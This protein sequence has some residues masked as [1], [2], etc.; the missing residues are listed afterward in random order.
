M[1]LISAGLAVSAIALFNHFPRAIAQYNAEL[2]C[3]GSINPQG[4]ISRPELAEIVSALNQKLDLIFEKMP[5]CRI[6]RSGSIVLYRLAWEE[7]NGIIIFRDP[8]TGVI[9]AYDFYITR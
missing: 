3:Q 7:E 2:Q 5:Y 4:V 6:S 8:Q 1:K 9:Q